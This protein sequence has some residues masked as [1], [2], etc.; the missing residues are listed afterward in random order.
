MKRYMGKISG[1][2]LDRIDLCVELQAVDVSSLQKK[3]AGESSRIIRE[4]VKQARNLQ[5]ERFRGRAIGL[6]QISRRQIWSGSA[7]WERKNR[8]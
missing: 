4:R 2:I 8:D 3:E 5:R 6:M 1:P 7:V